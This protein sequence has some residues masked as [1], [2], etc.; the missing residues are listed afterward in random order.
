MDEDA[1]GNITLTL[2]NVAPE[3]KGVYTVKA[4]NS[5]G[6]AKCFAQLIVKPKAKPAEPEEK[7]TLPVFKE[8]FGDV[9]VKEDDGIKFECV[10]VGKPTPKVSF[11]E[12]NHFQFLFPCFC[13]NNK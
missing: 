7:F 6:E 11:Y 13:Q 9:I 5:F 4:T 1:D 3:D 8:T 2:L 12:N 10:I